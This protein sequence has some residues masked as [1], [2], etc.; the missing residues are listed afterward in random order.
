MAS[1]REAETASNAQGVSQA[2]VDWALQN[3]TKNPTPENIAIAKDTY[4]AQQALIQS[5]AG[6]GPAGSYQPT[7]T[8]GGA[9]AGYK[10]T[11][12][13]SP[14]TQIVEDYMSTLK[15]AQALIPDINTTLAEIETNIAAVNQAG[16]EAGDIAS[17]MGGP[18]WNPISSNNNNNT[19]TTTARALLEAALRA[20]GIPEDMIQSSVAFLE[21]LDN[22][23]IDDV[24][25]M[26]S[27]YFNN[28]DYTTKGGTKLNSPFYQRYTSL[29][30]GVTNPATGRPY[31]GKE[32]F[33]WRTGIEQ[34]VSQYNLSDAF[35]TDDVLKKLVKAGRSVASFE[36]LAQTAILAETE[37]DPYKVAALRKMGYLGTDKGLRDFYLNPEIGQQQLEE[38]RRTGA[39]ATEALRY[40]EKGILFDEA[41]IKQI[42]AAYGNITESAAQQKANALYQTVGDSLQPTVTLAGIYERPTKTTGEM[43]G[44]IQKELENETLYSMASERRKR[45]AGL[46]IAEFQ[47]QSGT[48]QAYRTMSN[49]SLSPKSTTGLI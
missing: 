40:A 27:I 48:A 26:V 10:Y 34:K 14:S 2:A 23:G 3:A 36:E 8:I 31:T 1:F 41:R 28:K 13:V 44:D 5:A 12:Q 16:Q 35:K 49:V 25:D 45:L 38:N 22:D 43:T 21:A 15:S 33:A 6:K 32:M 17:R 24:A 42:G 19:G 47:G 39:I 11:P 4:A 9:P 37:A 20:E 29:A 7:I 18:G 46:N 30:E